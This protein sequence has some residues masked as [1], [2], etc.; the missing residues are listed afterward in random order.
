MNTAQTRIHG[1]P[2]QTG[3]SLI[4]LMIGMTLGLIVLGAVLY[5]FA[6]NRT[7]YRH[8]ESLSL[9]QE[10]GRFALELLARDI[11]MAGYAGCGN[12]G[13]VES[14][15]PA[16][17]SNAVAIAGTA[18]AG[19]TVPDVISLRRGG[20][21]LASVVTMPNAAEVQLDD[22]ALLGGVA[23]GDQLLITD[24]A[25]VEAFNV[26]S[27]AGN[28][29]T[30]AAALGRS[31][32]A[33]SQVMRLETVEYTVSPNNDLRRS[34]NGGVAQPVAEGVSNMKISYGID[35]SGNRNADTYVAD[36]G[37]LAPPA[38][39]RV[40]SVR[41]NLTVTDR[42]VTLPLSTT[43]TLRNRTP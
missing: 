37:A 5:V 43:L 19:A 33:G 38:W 9:V 25:F 20:F 26:Q 1:R 32:S 4:E 40:V 15:T 31:Y 24:C 36:P 6:G 41:I 34:V 8:Q 35:T 21:V 13:F 27:V 42:D 22:V 7:S 10:S 39:P 30:A 29:V 28:T 11:R 18:N 14:L 17:V 3:F 16:S 2:D 23:P 12:I